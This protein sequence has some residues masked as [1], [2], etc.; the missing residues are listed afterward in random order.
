VTEGPPDASRAGVDGRGNRGDVDRRGIAGLPT[1]Q[2][3]DAIDLPEA[4]TRSASGRAGR[5][6]PRGVL[7]PTLPK[8]LL[9]AMQRDPLGT[10][11][12]LC[13]P[14]TER[15]PLFRGGLVAST[16]AWTP[17]AVNVPV[18]KAVENSGD[19]LSVLL[20][21]AW[22]SV[23]NLATVGDRTWKPQIHHG[24]DQ[25]VGSGQLVDKEKLPCR[26]PKDASPPGERG[27]Q[28]RVRTARSEG[29]G[30]CVAGGRPGGVAG[31]WSVASADTGAWDTQ[32]H[33]AEISPASRTAR[34]RFGKAAGQSRA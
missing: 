14:L 33:D 25:P 3:I 18:R 31:R 19:N 20:T 23:D 30:R 8:F 6:S 29:G 5:P 26:S 12:A 28:R 11:P 9:T 17:Q 16:M 24:G 27:L 13:L 1:R 2:R 32:G 22:T 4:D 10:V 34:G 21:T 15:G 7:P